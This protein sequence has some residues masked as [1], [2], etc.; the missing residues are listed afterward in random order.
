MAGS[1]YEEDTHT[2]INRSGAN[3]AV[4]DVTQNTGGNKTSTAATVTAQTACI[5][6][7]WRVRLIRRTEMAMSDVLMDIT[8]S[9]PVWMEADIR[10]VVPPYPGMAVYCWPIPVPSVVPGATERHSVSE[11]AR[12]MP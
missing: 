8:P 11:A 10:T 6:P 4:K 9:I 3:A 2:T 7:L 12:R 1:D 5:S